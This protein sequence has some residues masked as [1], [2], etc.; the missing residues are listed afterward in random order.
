MGSWVAWTGAMIAKRAHMEQVQ[1]WAAEMLD[2]S[3][4]FTAELRI[5]GDECNHGHWL[6]RTS[7]GSQAWLE[8]QMA[9]E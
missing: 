4:G 6:H 3:L 5:G 8:N 7:H 1:V 9:R 2:L